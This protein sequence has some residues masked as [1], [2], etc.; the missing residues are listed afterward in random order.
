[1]RRYSDVFLLWNIL[2]LYIIQLFASLLLG[3]EDTIG[4]QFSRAICH[5]IRLPSIGRHT[6]RVVHKDRGYIQCTFCSV[7]SLQKSKAYK[8]SS[9]YDVEVDKW[10]NND[11]SHGKEPYRPIPGDIFLITD[12]KPERMSHLQQLEGVMSF[13]YNTKVSGDDERSTRT[14]TLLKVKGSEELDIEDRPQKPLSV[15]FLINITTNNRI[16][17]AMHSWGYSKI[18]KEVIGTNY[19]VQA[20]CDMCPLDRNEVLAEDLNL[21]ANLDE[22]QLEAVVS[23]ICNIKCNH[24]SYM[25]LIW[26]PPGTGKT[27]TV[28]MLLL[29]LLRLKFRTLTCA[30]TNVAIT[31][32]ASRVLKLVKE[33]FQ[34]QFPNHAQFCCLGDILL[35]GNMDRVAFN[36]EEI[37]L[38][39]RVEKLVECFGPV[40][41][42]KHCITSMV[43]FLDGVGSQYQMFCRNQLMYEEQHIPEFEASKV[44]SKSFLEFAR[45]RYKSAASALKRCVSILCTHVPKS[46]I[47]EQNFQH[48]VSLVAILDSFETLLFRDGVASE[49]LKEVFGNQW[50]VEMPVHDFQE[51]STLTS[52]RS[53]CL[54]VLTTLFRSLDGLNL[55]SVL[56]SDN[57][58]KSFSKLKSVETKNLSLLLLS[59]LSSGWRPKS[60]VGISCES[61]SNI[62]RKF[63]VGELYIVCSVDIVKESGFIQAL[64]VWDILPLQDIS[65]LVKRLDNIFSM[66]TEDYI[67]RCRVKRLEGNLEVPMHWAPTSHIVQYKSLSNSGTV[68]PIDAGAADGKSYVENSKVRDSL[69]LMKFYSLSSGAV[70]NL[71]S[72]CNGGDGLP[73]ELTEQEQEIVLFDRSTFVLGRSGTG[74]TT[75]LTMKLFRNEQLYHISSEGFHEVTSNPSNDVGWRYEVSES[76]G[77]A[78]GH[79]LRQLFVTV[80]PKLCYAVKR[81]VS[82]WKRSVCGGNSSTNS[83]S[84]R[85]NEIDDA[86]Q[87]TDIPDTFVDLSPKAY[88]LI[89][90][91]RKFLLM[92]DGTVGTSYFERF[93]DVRQTC[94]GIPSTSK[95]VILEAFIRNNEVNYDRFCSSYWPHFNIR[96]TKILDPSMVFT[97]IMSVI[98]GGLR[99]GDS[100]DGRLCQQDYVSISEDR[101]STLS[102]Q[103]REVV[104]EIF[105]EYEKKKVECGDFDIADLVID[106]HKRFKD[107]VYVGDEMDFVY[108]D[109]VQDL[110]MRQISLFKY[111]CRNVDE[112]F[113]F[114]GDTAQ[115][116]ARGID[117][118]FEDIRC[119]FYNEF[120]FGSRECATDRRSAKG[121]VSKIHHLSRNFRTHAGVLK[122]GESVLSLIYHFFPSS[123]DI[124]SPESSLLFGEAPILLNIGNNI[125]LMT[126][127]E[128]SGKAGDVVGF[129]AEQVILVRDECTKKEISD[130]VGKRALVLTIMECK[131]LEFQDVLLYNF[132]TSSPFQDEWRVIYGY[133]KDKDML[134]SSS[135]H[136]TSFSWEK[137]SV[138]CSEMKNLYVAIT[139]TKQRLWI[140]ENAGFSQPIFDYWKNSYLVEERQVDDAFIQ[141]MQVASNQEEWKSRGIKLYYENNYEAAMVCFERAGDAYWQKMAKASGLRAA[142][143][144]MHAPNS[145]TWRKYLKEAAKI[146][147]S[148]NIFEA[149][150][151]CYFEINEYK[152]AGN[153][154]QQKFG[155]PKLEKAG[156]C[157]SLAKCHELAA[158]AYARARSYSKCLS[159]CIDGKLFEMGLLYI[160]SWKEQTTFHADKLM[161]AHRSIEDFLQTGAL[162]YYELKDKRTMME[163]VKSF[164]SGDTM[165]NFLRKLDCLDELLSL[166]IESGNFLAAADIAKLKKDPVLEADFVE[167]AGLFREASMLILWHVF[168]NILHP[169]TGKGKPS[170]QFMQKKGLLTKA[171][172]I[173]KNHSDLFHEFVSTEA[174][175]L[176]KG[177]TA[178]EL[179][180][181]ELEFIVHWKSRA[182]SDLCRIIKTSYELNKIEQ[183]LLKKCACHYYD[184]K[185]KRTMMNYVKKFE[186][187]TLIREFLKGSNC[188]DELM[189]HE[190]ELGNFL[191]A[192]EIAHDLKDKRTM[193]N[194]V[195]K[196]ESVTL[197]REFL[198]GLNC[199]EELMVH[200]EELGNFLEAAEIAEQK[201]DI[202]RKADLLEK[203]GHFKD[204]SLSILWYVLPRSL[205]APKSKGWPLKQFHPKDKLLTKVISCAKNLPD[206]FCSFFCM[207]ATVL[208]NK[209]S[210]LSEMR[211]YLSASQDQKSLR[212][213]ILTA[214]KVLDAHFNVSTSK[215][216]WNASLVDNLNKHSEDMISE[217]QV[218]IETLV[219]FWNH[220]KEKIVGLIDYLLGNITRDVSEDARCEE[221]CLNYFGLQK[222]FPNKDNVYIVLFS[223]ANW[224]KIVDPRTLRRNGGLVFI[225]SRLFVSAALSYWYSALHSV[226]IQVLVTLDALHVYSIKSHFSMF[227]QSKCLLHIFGIANF[228]LNFK[229]PNR[230]YY[231]VS[232]VQKHLELSIKNLLGNVFHVDWRS[233]S[234]NDMISLRREASFVDLLKEAISQSIFSKDKLTF[235]QLGRVVMMILGS[236]KGTVNLHEDIM[237]SN[238]G[239]SVFWGAFTKMRSDK[240]GSDLS[241]GSENTGFSDASNGISLVWLHNML[242]DA[243]VADWR[244][245]HDYI[246]PSC[247]MYLVERLL[248]LASCF[249]GFVFT[250]KSSFVE[251]LIFEEWNVDSSSLLAND[252][253]QSRIVGDIH[254]FTAFLVQQLLLNKRDKLVWIRKSYDGSDNSYPLL[255]LRLVVLLCLVCVSSG[256]HLDKLYRLLEKRDV[257]S[258]LPRAFCDAL[259]RR[260]G[261]SFID[262]LADALGRIENPLVIVSLTGKIVESPSP[263]AI[264]LNMKAKMSSENIFRKLFQEKGEAATCSDD[265][266]NEFQVVQPNPSCVVEQ[267][268]STQSQIEGGPQ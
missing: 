195:K 166:E 73:F 37:H 157:F 40:T 54:R 234:T 253:E 125:N 248:I 2:M 126:I 239:N 28:S 210:S 64:K 191:E 1:M 36:V 51:K 185:D 26:G 59:K 223:D 132:F 249:Q 162:H 141:E 216:E 260:H 11:R 138:L 217:N 184:L 6:S 82:Q 81:H 89:I 33:S 174:N 121:R 148:I 110:S 154:Y 60:N 136:F 145:D 112:G 7:I 117:F 46:I 169:K 220:W 58:R 254:D 143:A 261:R 9:L 69:L 160:R 188:L 68:E 198:K 12:A 53:K 41:G 173:A 25:E 186:S 76:D 83:D 10:K 47:L 135:K 219:H 32:V 199:V 31:E 265:H 72:S 193:M 207:E 152:M 237:R 258:Q 181:M 196:F 90:T 94:Q 235:G 156:E 71:L 146:F 140:W 30:P 67:T 150:A 197:I 21:K 129:G 255:V 221:F 176:S 218:S 27:R 243:F 241:H 167:K 18:I 84:M 97:E 95:S 45:E 38:D 164:H 215:Y 183:Y 236:P 91:F 144:R 52:I 80:S 62:L 244:K 20:N 149:S 74:K 231:D 213:E 240:I 102:M 34:T 163:F 127:L 203:A 206:P 264:F 19:V 111:I 86:A 133:M 122:L 66:Y 224:L 178:G 228:L 139:R 211:K 100:H 262:A 209:E 250:T 13:G 165:R 200:E 158:E 16:W 8:T 208:S 155:E 114:S 116:I 257:S 175:I 119:L 190:E 168:T 108:I 50:G 103:K 5:S 172:S 225:E 130:Y 88:P 99:T 201:R 85:M 106:L 153:I 104:Y 230:K 118:R 267:V 256:K 233:S 137:H 247:L 263:D 3:G 96:L 147:Y 49:E 266:G 93:R 48:M 182:P 87:F 180:E 159:A 63:K 131:G 75:V 70:S 65:K 23:S 57:F 44:Q 56:F 113:V 134:K 142:A 251:W 24:R 120:V 161:E 128:S 252:P 192:A 78:K 61:S 202:P 14:G 98:K 79:I 212:C 170:N 43:E 55:P 35:F 29:S 92:L 101:G 105:L 77:E 229:F 109:E 268:L 107:E 205:W 115:T 123:V 42:W 238:G 222:H 214:W 232:N 17:N 189:V 177:K 194:Y 226:G 171:K 151:Q 179:L 22:S 246:S 4:I 245:E 187:V 204:A 39:Y 242:K 124:L 259:G 227:L 15:V